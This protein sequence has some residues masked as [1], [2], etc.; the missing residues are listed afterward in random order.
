M[1][2]SLNCLFLGEAPIRSIPVII[3]EEIT[4]GNN[5]IK[6]EK[7]TISNV[8]SLILSE[9]GI[10]CCLDN[11]NLW[12]VNIVIVNENDKV[13]EIS[14]TEDDIKEKLGGE[15]MNPRTS[16]GKY[17]NENSFKDEESESAIH[18][19]VQLPT[20]TMTLT[21]LTIALWETNMPNEPE[22]KFRNLIRDNLTKLTAG[23]SNRFWGEDLG[24]LKQESQNIDNENDKFRGESELSETLSRLSMTEASQFTA[25]YIGDQ[26][27]LPI[28]GTGMLPRLLTLSDKFWSTYRKNTPS[29][30]YMNP[31]IVNGRP[32]IIAYVHVPKGTPV[33]LPAEFE[34]Y[35]VFID[36]GVI[37]PA[38]PAALSPGISISSTSACTLGALF[39]NEREPTK[40]F[41]LT[42][43]HS[44]G[45]TDSMVI[46]PG[47]ADAGKGYTAC[48]KV[49]E[50]NFYGVI[51][52]DGDAILLD[53]AFC[54][55]INSEVASTNNTPIQCEICINNT[56]DSVSGSGKEYEIYKVGGTTNYAKGVITDK[57]ESFFNRKF[58]DVKTLIVRSN[59]KIFGAPGDSGSP[60]FDKHNILWGILQGISPDSSMVSVVPIHLILQHVRREFEVS[61]KLV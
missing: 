23:E 31:G 45:N 11:L 12:K 44:V 19:I 34:G 59:K 2:L 49:S 27:I 7:I 9:K 17:F 60:V 38:S 10:S 21:T 25:K 4:V 6:Y 48:A 57:L 55:V 13:L 5:R 20:L 41:I 53:Y 43:K 52:E 29:L 36:Y 30:S 37:E 28:I 51:Y 40:T 42:T 47:S 22:A 8:K 54:E 16:L 46:H 26:E 14:S 15:L 35:P 32:A 39:K 24:R 18:I 58:G 3:S 1:I 50:Y 56:K 61:F 33:E